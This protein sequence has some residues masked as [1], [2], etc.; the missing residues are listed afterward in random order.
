M[1]RRAR[2]FLAVRAQR[3]LTVAVA[4]VMLCLCVMHAPVRARQQTTPPASKKPSGKTAPVASKREG[5]VDPMLAVRRATAISLVTSLADEARSF[6]D[7]ALRARVQA[8]AADVLWETDKERALALFRRG[9]DEAEAADVETAR[10]LNEE[11]RKQRASGRQFAAGRRSIRTEVLR[12][13]ARRD[14]ALGEEFLARLDEKKK[15]EADSALDSNKNAD[16]NANTDA[17]KSKDDSSSRNNP[18]EASPAVAKRLELAGQLLD[19]GD[20]ERAIQIADPALASVNVQAIYFLTQLRLKNV[21]AADERFASLLA[22][23]ASDPAADANVASI[24]SS[25]IYTPGLFIR[26]MADAGTNSSRYNRDQTAPADIPA[27]LRAAFLR[28]AAAILLR[29]IPP[30]EMDHSSAGRA[31]WYLVIARMLPLFDSAA[32]DQS[33]L[34]RTQMAA[35]TPD[36]PDDARD[37]GRFALTQGLVP[38]DTTRDRVQEVLNRLDHAKT[39]EERD[40]T[41]ADAIL[42]A[43]NKKDSRVEEFISKINDADLRAR[44]RAYVDYERVR[45]ALEDKDVTE[46]LRIT[47]AGN[48]TAI[49]RT[50]ALTQVAKLVSKKEPGRATEFLDEATTEAKRV[51]AGTSERVSALVAIATQLVALN[52]QRAW[53]VMNEIVKASNAAENFTGEDGE[54]SVHLETKFMSST[55]SN[56]VDSFDLEGLFK[57]LAKED[58]NR[59]IEVARSFNGESPRA[60]ATLAVARA[61]L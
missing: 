54:L 60:V 28:T 32:P 10:R 9:W 33:A 58:L 46:T 43:M 51:D 30:A 56:S 20:V 24:L 18:T 48:L 15:E 17:A 19:V 21:A 6:R 23:A 7:P 50:W 31:G 2:C 49:Q 35:L 11:L 1:L 55:T 40:A 26:F 52:R 34:L 4:A 14:R 39:D 44:V 13:A 45:L 22:R 8:R 36:M 42:S 16:A 38:E 41:Y 37:P 59:T 12:L 29:P 53:E 47:R 57:L 3:F 27:P 61:I 5:E 25:Y